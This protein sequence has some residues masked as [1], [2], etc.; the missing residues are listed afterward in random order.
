MRI[1]SLIAIAAIA[2]GVIALVHGMV[3]GLNRPPAAAATSGE[4][5]PQQ[6]IDEVFDELGFQRLPLPPGLPRQ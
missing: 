3:I 5:T 4:K 1:P 2:A 6:R